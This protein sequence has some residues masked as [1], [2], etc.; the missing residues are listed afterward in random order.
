MQA[1]SFLDEIPETVSVP[2]RH[3]S[4]DE[5]ITLH[6][7]R[8][9]AE[10]IGD[11]LV[12]GEGTI[13]IVWDDRPQILFDWKA[14]N[15]HSN[16]SVTSTDPIAIRLDTG[17]AS[18]PIQSST[19]AHFPRSAAGRVPEF[20]HRWEETVE[21]LVSYLANFPRIEGDA[22]R[23]DRQTWRGR[24]Q[25]ILDEEWKI[26]IDP[27]EAEALT[28]FQLPSKRNRLTHVIEVCRADQSKFNP[29]EC[30]SLLDFLHWILSF[31]RAGYSMAFYQASFDSTSNLIGVRAVPGI[32]R[33]TGHPNGCLLR[34]R[35]DGES[36]LHELIPAAWRAAKTSDWPLLQSMI[37]WYLTCLDG[38]LEQRVIV[39]QI[40]FEEWF[41]SLGLP[42]K[43]AY[44]CYENKLAELKIDLQIP[45]HLQALCKYQESCQAGAGDTG[46]KVITEVRNKLG[47]R[48]NLTV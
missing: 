43:R 7:G 39:C 44:E 10:Y 32:V 23:R 21:R 35:G 28:D 11:E 2:I 24:L 1:R 4:G 22:I 6:E 20:R 16:P 46:P 31:S 25:F 45:S 12:E 33:R 13:Q 14:F 19:W 42:E 29:E 9:F 40:A 8:Y 38:V 47:K 3:L 34:R 27:L 36:G 41:R 15:P 18:L 5:P 48:P 37:A 17:T 26:T 30:S